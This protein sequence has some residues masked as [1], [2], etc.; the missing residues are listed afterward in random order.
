ML[1]LVR[2]ALLVNVALSCLVE[3]LGKVFVL[4]VWLESGKGSGGVTLLVVPWSLVKL[5]VIEPFL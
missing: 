1:L 2:V 3:D 4:R 5:A